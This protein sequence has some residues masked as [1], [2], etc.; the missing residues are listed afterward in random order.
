ME[1]TKNDMRVIKSILV[2]C[3]REGAYSMQNITLIVY[4]YKSIVNQGLEKTIH[5]IQYV[6][7]KLNHC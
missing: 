4:E 5:V 1:F 2:R 6:Y 3:S 7:N